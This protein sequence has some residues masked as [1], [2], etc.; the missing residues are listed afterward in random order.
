[1]ARVY[2]A[3]DSEQVRKDLHLLLELDPALEIIGEADSINGLLEDVLVKS[4]DVLIL[5]LE[6]SGGKNVKGLPTADFPDACGVI[7]QIKRHLP[8]VQIFILTMHDYP[9]SR[10][11]SLTAGAD[12]FFVKGQVGNDLFD[13]INHR[14]EKKEK[15][16]KK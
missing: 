7:R 4:P 9:E 6:F 13:A 16:E 12:K 10:T 14:I 8:Q 1:M 3:D 15:K 2:I 5:D 11:A